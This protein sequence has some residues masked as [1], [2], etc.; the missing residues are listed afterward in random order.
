MKIIEV[1]SDTNIGGAGILL[2]NRLECTD[3]RRYPT[4][5]CLPQKSKLIPRFEQIGIECIGTDTTPDSSWNL[6]DVKKFKRIFDRER[7][8]VVNCHGSL[9]ARVAAKMWGVPIKICTRHCVYPLS[10]FEKL[11]GKLNSSLSD[12]FIAVAYS[13]KENLMDMGVNEN[14]IHVI[15]NGA[16]ALKLTDECERRNLKT[17]LGISENDLV[18]SICARLETCKG[19]KILFDAV[20]ILKERGVKCVVL[21]IGDGSQREDLE[22][23]CKEN[24]LSKN[25]IFLGFVDDVYRYMNISDLNI[26]CS[27]GTETSSLAL[28]EGMSIGL[29]AVVSDYGG[30]PYM[31]RH[32]VNGYVYGCGD[33]SR[34]AELI[35]ELV[36]NRERLNEMSAQARKRYDT[37]LNAEFMTKKTNRLY[38]ELIDRQRIG[39]L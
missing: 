5:V 8:T 1:I 27:V 35:Y 30:N 12:A 15:I 10:R 16:K 6:R 19:H 32:G 34:L 11:T 39:R 26:N 21:V 13:A 36:T 28:S 3:M 31:I 20:K 17:K 29:P 25:T 14:K 2:L 37:E 22:K 18:L 24:N 7:P 9:S 23:Y 4:L 38:D 33:S